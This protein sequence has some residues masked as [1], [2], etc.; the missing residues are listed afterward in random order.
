MNKYLYIKK[1]F[2]ENKNDLNALSMSKYMRN[3][4]TFYGISTSIRRNLYKDFLKE[5]KKSKQI[6]WK[7]LT[8]CYMEPMREFQYLVCDYLIYMKKYL[9][10]EDINKIKEFIETKPWWDTVD[11]LD[12]LVGYLALNDKKID[13][14]MLLWSK[15]S[16]IWL[17][18]IAI[19]Y[20][21]GRKEKTNTTVL[22]EI[23]FNNLKNK[24]FFINKAIGWILRDYSK[25]NPEWVRNFICKYH[26][27]MNK[28]SIKE[29]SKYL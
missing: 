8:K 7:F 1:L 28:L 10:S 14:K 6:D 11:S 9:V 3:Q 29:A 15:D 2:E 20:Q 13:E 5:E 21:L 12:Q 25:T 19:D 16:N 24:E 26:D 18:R 22:E 27:R 17:R 23:L 4:F